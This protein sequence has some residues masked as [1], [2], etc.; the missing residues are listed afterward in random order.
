MPLDDP[1]AMPYTNAKCA[2][3]TE[4]CGACAELAIGAAT[5]K[6]AANEEIRR[7]TKVQQGLMVARA[8]GIPSLLEALLPSPTN[9]ALER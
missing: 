5:M 7:F 2:S 9:L 6:A 3:R 4:A 1:N 8:C